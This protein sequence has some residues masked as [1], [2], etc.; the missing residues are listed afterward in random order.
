MN[1]PNL[2]ST[3][4][5]PQ[6][7]P[8]YAS[9]EKMDV[10]YPSAECAG[11]KLE[12]SN[13]DVVNSSS[14]TQANKGSNC[15]LY[16]I[17]NLTQFRIRFHDAYDGKDYIIQRG[18]DGCPEVW[19]PLATETHSSLHLLFQDGSSRQF[20]TIYGESDDD[21]HITIADHTRSATF[22][23]HTS[24]PFVSSKGCL[25]IFSTAHPNYRID[26]F[27]HNPVIPDDLV[28]IFYTTCPDS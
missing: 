3:P 7:N 4:T 6:S 14:K 5:Q 8:E 11:E 19:L 28:N 15:T 1:D 17:K 2:V 9:L 16:R 26:C 27:R 25:T 12:V 24:I 21:Q 23:T 10:L 20:L 22:P 18:T 13:N